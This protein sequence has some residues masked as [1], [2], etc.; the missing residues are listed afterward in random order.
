MP[1]NLSAREY[2]DLAARDGLDAD[3]GQ[4]DLAEIQAGRPS[5]AG[6]GITV[7][8]RGGW[9]GTP[10]P[11]VTPDRGHSGSDLVRRMKPPGLRGGTA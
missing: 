7:A 11:A 4:F 9:G 2:A 8:E 5:S 6:T 1:S 3:R 10:S